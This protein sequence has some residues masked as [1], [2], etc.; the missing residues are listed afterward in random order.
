MTDSAPRLEIVPAP[1]DKPRPFRQDGLGYI[2]EPDT[3]RVRFRADYLKRRSDELWGT[4]TVTAT[5]PGVPSHLHESTYN[6]SSS[7]I[8]TSLPK[9]LVEMS[10]GALDQDT[11]RSF[12][13]KFCTAVVRRE[14]E[15]LPIVKVG[16][17][18][19]APFNPDTVQRILPA[20]RPTL[21]YGPP[22][23]AKGWISAAVAVHCL[24]GIPF[25]GLEVQQRNPFVLDWEDDA[26]TLDWRIKAIAAG[27]ELSRVP[28]LCYKPSRGKTLVRQLHSIARHCQECGH[29]H[30]LVDS[31][32]HAAGPPG[33]HGSWEDQALSMFNGIAQLGSITTNLI[34]HVSGEAS[35]EKLAGKAIGAYRKMMDARAAWEF[36]VEQEAGSSELHVGLYHTKHNHT[37]FF[38]PIGIRLRFES[39][40]YGRAIKVVFTRAD[41]RE[42][43]EHFERLSLVQRVEW[44]LLREQMRPD[45][46][47]KELGEKPN[48]VRAT[49]ANYGHGKTKQRFTRR[50]D[51]TWGVLAA[52]PGPLT[53]RAH[54]ERASLRALPYKEDSDDDSAI[55]PNEPTSN[56]DDEVPF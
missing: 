33:D 32:G 15:G 6:L 22:G 28:E 8:R 23:A 1:P 14:N 55:G 26:E 24:L 21:W 38:D 17:L 5:L 56:A 29:D 42:R 35:K 10:K 51:G 46:L 2:Y 47:A 25:V 7:T 18:A 37:E 31:V 52:E 9:L 16:G 20:G 41:L 36:R 39:D 13:E 44:T 48:A 49:L 54:S 53:E 11:W 12:I 50:M 45:E 43:P 40:V 19:V 30:L 4:I 27:L 3:Q 34:D